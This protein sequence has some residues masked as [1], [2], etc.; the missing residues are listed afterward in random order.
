MHR[1][2][3]SVNTTEQ[4]RYYTPRRQWQSMLSRRRWLT[5]L[6]S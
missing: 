5:Q 3:R 4:E 1:V 2:T 6:V